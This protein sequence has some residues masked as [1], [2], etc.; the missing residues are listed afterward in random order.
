MPIGALAHVGIA[1]EVTFG[2][3]VAATDYIKFASEGF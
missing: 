2:T 1:K 3:A